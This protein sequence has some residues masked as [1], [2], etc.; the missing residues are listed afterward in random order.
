MRWEFTHPDPFPP[1]VVRDICCGEQQVRG[2][3]IC[4][5][6]DEILEHRQRFVFRGVADAG[7]GTRPP[8]TITISALT[9]ERRVRVRAAE[10]PVNSCQLIPP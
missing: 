4:V 10:D 3:V 9:V 1:Q 7:P 5:Q 2:R 8:S 6:M